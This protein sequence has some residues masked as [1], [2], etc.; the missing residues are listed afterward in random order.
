[1]LQCVA[2][3]C[4]VLQCVAVCCSV[5]QCV[6]VC[7]SVLQCIADVLYHD[8]RHSLSHVNAKYHDIIQKEINKKN[9]P[10]HICSYVTCH[11]VGMS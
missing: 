10:T 9:C 6:A 1:M 2:V 4:S 5:L 7:C 3:C 8:T 11:G